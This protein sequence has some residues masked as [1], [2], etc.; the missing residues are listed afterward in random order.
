LALNLIS[1]LLCVIN[2]NNAISLASSFALNAT[3]ASLGFHVAWHTVENIAVAN[4]IVIDLILYPYFFSALY[5][6]INFL[7]SMLL[8]SFLI[9]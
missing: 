1:S 8:Y 7:V 9:T 2:L 4:N 3:S 6:S 5:L